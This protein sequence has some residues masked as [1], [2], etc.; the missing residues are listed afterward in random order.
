MDFANL[1]K[2]E[3]NTSCGE[4]FQGKVFTASSVQDIKAIVDKRQCDENRPLCVSG[5]HRILWLGNSQLHYINQYKKGDHLSPYWLR[6]ADKDPACVEPLGFSLPNASFQEFLIISRYAVTRIPTNVVIIEMV[7]DDLREDGLRRDFDE[8]LTAKVVY[9]MKA[10][11]ITADKILA[12]HL[13][14]NKDGAVNATNNALTGSLQQPLENWLNAGL[15][16]IWKLWASRPDL[17]ANV[18]LAIY[19]FRNFVLGINPTSI[20]HMIKTRY[21]LNMEALLDMLKDFKHRGIPVI[22]YIAPIRQ[23]KPIPYDLKEYNLWKRE[24]AE[25]AQQ[26]GADIVNLEQLVPGELLGSYV[27]DDIDFM[28]FQGPGHKLVAQALLPHVQMAIQNG[29]R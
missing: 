17:E 7:F 10:T 6:M 29:L 1:A 16:S 18:H 23:D 3:Q 20:R 5:F 4:T 24:V 2:G 15:A 28:H 25:K 14:S 9:E 27:G 19:N 12:R 8:L 22:L 21:D 26:F 13:G 11:S